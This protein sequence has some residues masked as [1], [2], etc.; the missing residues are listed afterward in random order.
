MWE[1]LEKS[2]DLID[3]AKQDPENST[4]YLISAIKIISS[5]DSNQL[6]ANSIK[7]SIYSEILWILKDTY[8]SDF[9]LMKTLISAVY[10]MNSKKKRNKVFSE[11]VK[12]ILKFKIIHHYVNYYIDKLQLKITVFNKDF[13][14]AFE[15]IN[16][17]P[18]SKINF[19]KKKYNE[20][21]KKDSFKCEALS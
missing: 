11:I 3:R 15:L 20:N 1:E 8:L 12:T 7:E 17:L 14:K 16:L 13:D 6:S 10:K 21:F 18:E 4:K 9:D 5:M 2:Q 19:F